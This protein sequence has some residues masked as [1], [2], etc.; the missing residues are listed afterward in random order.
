MDDCMYFFRSST[1]MRIKTHVEQEV[2]R[3]SRVENVMEALEGEITRSVITACNI[4]NMEI[5][6]SC[7]E[8][9]S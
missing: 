1:Q 9:D 5:S 7:T 8:E 4:P 2:V 6:T 3:V